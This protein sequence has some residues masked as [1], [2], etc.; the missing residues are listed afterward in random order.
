MAVCEQHQNHGLPVTFMCLHLPLACVVGPIS[1]HQH[2]FSPPCGAPALLPVG[3][4]PPHMWCPL[5]PELLE[6]A[7]SWDTFLFQLIHKQLWQIYHFS[8][9]SATQ[10]VVEREGRSKTLLQPHGPHQD[11]TLLGK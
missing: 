9:V 4:H 7:L 8:D 10:G 2:N 5:S 1:H 3:S 11:F 6:N